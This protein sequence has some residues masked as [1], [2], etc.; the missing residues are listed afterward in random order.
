[1][2]I[3]SNNDIISHMSKLNKFV[4]SIH[5][6]LCLDD[7]D[8]LPSNVD[9][10]RTFR[11]NQSPQNHKQS[12]QSNVN[13]SSFSVIEYPHFTILGFAT[14]H[15]DYIEQFLFHTKPCLS[16]YITLH[17]NYHRRQSIAKWD[18]PKQFHTFLQLKLM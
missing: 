4:F 5:S 11:D 8:Y 9:T 13:N 18:V 1:M 17:F 16:N 14:I 3:I 2:E 15:D 10:Q 7:L 12:Q 6:N